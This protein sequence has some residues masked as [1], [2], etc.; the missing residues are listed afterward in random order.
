M[1]RGFVIAA[2][3][4]LAAPPAWAQA[5]GE[6]AAAAQCGGADPDQAI[7]GCT[8]IIQTQ[9]QT[10]EMLTFAY[11]DRA[12][13]YHRKG[14]DQSGL[15]DV[16]MALVLAPNNAAI[17]ETRAEI[18]EKL[19]KRDAAIADYRAALKLDPKMTQANDGLK[20]LNATP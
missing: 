9:N 2:A 15:R 6:Q 8:Q 20:R 11:N 7:A 16:N 19:G 12:W 13:A 4:L 14:D 3:L 10:K 5:A 18:N 1:M 17:I